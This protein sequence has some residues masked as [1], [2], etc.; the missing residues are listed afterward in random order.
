[1]PG[2]YLSMSMIYT[3]AAQRFALADC[4]RAWTLFAGRK[5]L[6]ARKMLDAKHGDRETSYLSSA[7]CVGRFTK[8]R[9]AI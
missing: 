8:Q 7:R 1:M 5:K 4:A 6:E 2:P 3:Y 9:L